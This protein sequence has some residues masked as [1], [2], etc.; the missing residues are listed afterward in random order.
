MH[1]PH[2]KVGTRK[3]QLALIQAQLVQKGLL[4]SHP[5]LTDQMITIEPLIT[6]GDKFK[7][8]PLSEIGGKGLFCKEIDRKLLAGEVDIAVHSAKD[9]EAILPPELA[10]A[11]VLKRADP[12]DVFLSTCAS[13][14]DDL[15]YGATVGTSSLRRKMQ[16][17]RHR[18][19]IK[20]VNFRGNV[21]TRLAKLEE[22]V[23]LATILA[24]AGLERLGLTSKITY[25]FPVTQMLPAVGQGT[26]SIL[27][28][29]NDEKMK[30]LLAPLNH[31]ETY[32]CLLAERAFLKVL[33]ANCH[34]PIAG[35][36]AYE[37]KEIYL[38]GLVAE[39]NPPFALA[40]GEARGDDPEEVGTRL[41]Q[42]LRKKLGHDVRD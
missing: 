6:K 14:L 18:P 12:R 33:G 26:I 7:E 21:T 9:M 16:L 5:T 15:P 1:S 35:Y 13:T 27:V 37:G 31:P 38:R 4:D 30:E 22:G 20:I 41:G 40:Q 11:A 23:A 42:E 17:L 36:A 34:M 32:R 28:R 2:I 19:D 24:R 25:T 3:S 10:I 39:E 29:A 8:R